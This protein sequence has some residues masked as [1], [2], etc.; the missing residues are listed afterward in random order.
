MSCVEAQVQ[1]HLQTLL[2][3][4]QTYT[5][6]QNQFPPDLDQAPFPAKMFWQENLKNQNLVISVTFLWFMFFFLES[7]A[8]DKVDAA[9]LHHALSWLID[10]CQASRVIMSSH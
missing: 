4:E 2:W 9:K 7:L 3:I 6:I 8:F 1:R 10:Q 5:Q